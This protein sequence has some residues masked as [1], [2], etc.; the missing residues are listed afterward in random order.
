MRNSIDFWDGVLKG[1][2][3]NIWESFD[4]MEKTRLDRVRSRCGKIGRKIV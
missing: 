2:V 3:E 4:S 1:R